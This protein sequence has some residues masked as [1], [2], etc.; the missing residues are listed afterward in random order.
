MARENIFRAHR[1]RVLAQKSAESG[2]S[3]VVL[4]AATRQADGLGGIVPLTAAN[5]QAALMLVKLTSDRARLKEIQS[6]ERKI[7]AK[8]EMLADYQSWLDGLIEAADSLPDAVGNDVLTTC[9]MWHIDTGDFARALHLGAV[10][11]DRSI[12]MPS[13]FQR[14]A[15]CALAENIAEAA[16]DA[17][18]NKSEF[19]V[20]HVTSAMLI[21]ETKD[22]PDEVRAKLFKA[23]AMLLDRN[24]EA[25]GSAQADGPAGA[26][27]A[28]LESALG[29]AARA[30][31]LNSECGVKSLIKKLEGLTKKLQAE[32]QKATA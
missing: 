13:W 5:N 26:Y 19:D 29:A 20:D 10:V 25:I 6:V 16:F 3:L 15:A 22:M 31:Q 14:T 28:T 27:A 18:R 12:P 1:E 21:T 9:M 4:G 23:Q 2:T 17:I 24:A 8:R 7:D 32:A 11:I 30:L